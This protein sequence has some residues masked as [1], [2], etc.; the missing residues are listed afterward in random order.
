MDKDRRILYWSKGAERI[1]GYGATEVLGSHCHDNLLV[2][3]DARGRSL[4]GSNSVLRS[5]PLMMVK[6]G[7]QK[8]TFIIRMVIAYRYWH[9]F[10]RKE[11]SAEM[12]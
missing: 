10:S 4:C 2:H 9:G 6:S 11:E 5:K 1:T 8:Y 7:K 3:A 12:T